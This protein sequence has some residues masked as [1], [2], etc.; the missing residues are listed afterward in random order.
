MACHSLHSIYSERFISPP[1]KLEDYESGIKAATA[2]NVE[3]SDR[4]TTPLL[5]R[6][7]RLNFDRFPF[8]KPL[9]FHKGENRRWG[10]SE[11]RCRTYFPLISQMVGHR[12]RLHR[13]T[14]KKLGSG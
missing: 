3:P 10:L 2:S 5:A 4:L 7:L 6:F 1:I 12:V 8:D 9:P 13:Y 14:R 11:P